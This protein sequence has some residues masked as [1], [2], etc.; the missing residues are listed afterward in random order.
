M[1]MMTF[2]TDKGIVTVPLSLLI[3]E[4]MKIENLE[5]ARSLHSKIERIEYEQIEI[6]A[7]DPKWKHN[8]LKLTTSL[9]EAAIQTIKNIAICDLEDQKRKMLEEVTKLD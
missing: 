9:S 8:G 7:Y 2:L 6:R 5:K 4:E 1:A 3:E